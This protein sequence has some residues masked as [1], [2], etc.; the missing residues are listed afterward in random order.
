M[1]NPKAEPTILV[2]M[3]I[4]GDLTAKKV[5]PALF[6]LYKKGVLG[7]QF[8]IVGFGRK[9]YNNETIKP[10]IADLVKAKVKQASEKDLNAFTNLFSYQQGLFESAEAYNNLKQMLDGIQATWQ[11]KTNRLF[12]LAVPPD[13][14]EL[15]F[16]NL[17]SSGLTDQAN[18]ETRILVEKP[19]GSNL[20]SAEKLD[21]LLGSLFSEDKIYRIDHYL[22]KEMVQNILTFRFSNDIFEKIWNNQSIGKIEIRA[23]ET[24]GVEQ[25]GAFYDNVGA[26]RDFGQNHLLQILA[27]ITMDAPVDYSA[28]AIQLKR[29]QLMK[30]LKPMT[31]EDLKIQ[32]FRAQYEGYSQIAGVKADTNTETYFKIK[33]ELNHPKWTGVPIYMETGKR[34][35]EQLKDVIVTFKHNEGCLCPPGLHYTNRVIFSLE[36]EEQIRIEF[37]VKKPG[38]TDEMEQ[39][40]LDFMLR[41]AS[42]RL[43]YI[44]EYEKLFMDSINGDQTLFVSTSEVRSMWAFVDPIINAWE[45][46]AVELKNYP[47]DTNQAADLARYL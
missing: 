18:A 15:I 32:T 30:T 11:Q 7:D 44:E 2:I 45:S 34:M 13:I 37:W 23:W 33:A 12:Y 26:L 6:S 8:R 28:H 16:T 9:P 19:F 22:A 42:Q 14:Y 4:T 35:A 36:P 41:H 40:S 29:A 20:K 25:R 21:E 1:T 38:L 27:L 47:P 46:N 39:R 24:L 43:Q 5:V 3:G 17:K 10:F 31:A